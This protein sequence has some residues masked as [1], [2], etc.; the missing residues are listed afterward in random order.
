MDEGRG[1]AGR[2]VSWQPAP[3]WV[4]HCR[5]VHFNAKSSSTGAVALEAFS[6]QGLVVSKIIDSAMHRD[7]AVK[8]SESIQQRDIIDYSRFYLLFIF[9][10][11]V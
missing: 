6:C 5:P 4:T 8:D 11:F 1:G 2:S 3:V 10:T 7:S 9:L